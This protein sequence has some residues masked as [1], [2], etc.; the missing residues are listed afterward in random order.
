MLKFIC[1][2]GLQ[3]I[4]FLFGHKNN[5]IGKQVALSIQTVL[6]VDCFVMS[7]EKIK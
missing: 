3:I 6:K 4:Y 1:T 2:F 5:F 7:P